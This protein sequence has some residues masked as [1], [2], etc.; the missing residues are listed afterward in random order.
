MCT[1]QT[2]ANGDKAIENRTDDPV[3]APDNRSRFRSWYNERLEKEAKKA[4]ALAIDPLDE[5][6]SS[7]VPEDDNEEYVHENSTQE[8]EDVEESDVEE[9]DSE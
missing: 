9:S 4:A 8:E 7:S 2:V 6:D 5:N 1:S 3:I